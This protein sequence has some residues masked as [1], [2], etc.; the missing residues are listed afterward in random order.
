MNQSS[1]KNSKSWMERI[2]TVLLGEPKDRTH[3]I[4]LLRDAEQR[5]ILDAEALKM[6]EG[7]LQVSEM[8]VNEVMVP[9]SEMVVVEKTSTLEE[10]LPI[11]IS[12]AHSRF[13][14]IGDGK[15]EVIGILLA[16]DLL[17]Y[18]T[19]GQQ[20][21]FNFKDILRPAIFIPESKRLDILLNEFRQSRNHLA[22][23][24]DEYG[25]V[26]GLASIEDVLEQIVGD[27][28]DEYDTQD[29]VFIRQ[30]KNHNYSVKAVTP[31]EQF[32][33]Y[34]NTKLDSNEFDTVGG[35]ILKAFGRLPKRG[36]SIIIEDIPFKVLRASNRRINLLQTSYQPNNE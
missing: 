4:N 30:H 16:K 17:A 14:V 21:N 1:A 24:V 28:E 31:I 32:N 20:D 23:I 2:A 12:S 27:I 15:D 36:E 25:G 8:R 34:F 11:I 5:E 9:R 13:P 29:D 35:L 7:V 10:I 33:S 19:P 26:S 6:I 3:L 22:I 18:T